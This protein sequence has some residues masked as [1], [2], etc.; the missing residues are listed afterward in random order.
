MN[1]AC[2]V[3]IT[4]WRPCETFDKHRESVH[5][6]V[7]IHVLILS[8][9]VLCVYDALFVMAKRELFSLVM[10]QISFNTAERN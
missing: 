2:P 7:S 6:V 9:G 3:F 5:G 8:L 1:S 10:A 4:A